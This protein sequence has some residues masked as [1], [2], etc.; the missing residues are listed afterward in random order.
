MLDD[1]R[2]LVGR[3]SPDQARH[4]DGMIRLLASIGISAAAM[5]RGERAAA[6]TRWTAVRE[7]KQIAAEIAV[8]FNEGDRPRAQIRRMV[9]VMGGEWV[10]AV[11]DAAS[12]AIANEGNPL[13]IR[14]DAHARTP[15]GVFFECARL[16]AR[17]MV[18]AGKMTPK[19]FYAVFC[20]RDR[21]PKAKAAKPPPK[22]ARRQSEPEVIILRRR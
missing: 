19:Q 2:I 7:A 17:P 9:A 16:A 22:P 12:A 21:K 6:Y 1:R 4:D 13:L 18:A 15:G 14:K 11:A 20:W 5:T 3:F 10:R 8:R